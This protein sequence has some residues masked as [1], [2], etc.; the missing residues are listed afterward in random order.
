ML[1]P[2]PIPVHED[3]QQCE[4]A[5]NLCTGSPNGNKLLLVPLFCEAL[6]DIFRLTYLTQ[7]SHS[8]GFKCIR[9]CFFGNITMHD[10]VKDRE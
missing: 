6:S 9:S 4:T 7:F 5:L 3:A 10:H 1:P 2:E 8:F